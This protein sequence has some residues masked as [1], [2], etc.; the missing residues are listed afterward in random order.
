MTVSEL[1]PWHYADP[2]F[3][4]PPAE[5]AVDL[6]PLFKGKDIVGLAGTDVRRHRVRRRK[7]PRAERSLPSARKEPA[8]VL[9]RRRPWRRRSRPRQRRRQ[10]WLDRH[11]APRAR[12]RGLRPRIRRGAVVG[13]ARYAPRHDRGVRASLRRAGR[14]PGMAR[15]RPRRRCARGG[16]ARRPAAFRASCRAPGLHALGA[17][18]E[19]VR[20]RALCRP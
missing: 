10:P 19:R 1:R 12:P 13:V 9:H 5:G 7:N 16:R 20:A 6:D 4:Q 18:H 2:F 11:D 3:Q 17:G 8:R 14:R 15:A